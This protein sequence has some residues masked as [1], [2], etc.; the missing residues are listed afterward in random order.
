MQIILSLFFS[1]I[2]GCL[3]AYIAA[4]RKRRATL[5]FF[6]GVFAGIF[7]L[8][9]VLLLPPPKE[10]AEGD[11]LTDW[12]NRKEKETEKLLPPLSTSPY[13]G[14]EWYYVDQNRKALG[15]VSWT[16]LRELYEQKEINLDTLIWYEGLGDWQKAKDMENLF[17]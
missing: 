12:I 14:K 6:I 11:S 5:W 10:P 1:L 15:P 17:S 2:F 9:I 13:E 3:S 16:K 8:L 7:G 4:K